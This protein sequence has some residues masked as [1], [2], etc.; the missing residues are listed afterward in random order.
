MRLLHKFML[1]QVCLLA[2][3][4]QQVFAI[5]TPVTLTG[6][7]ADVVAD[8][9]GNAAGSTTADYDGVNYVWMSNS[10]NPGGTYMP[11]GG[12]FTS[13]V[14]STPGL[15]YQ[16]A[17]YTANNSLRMPG[18]STGTL[19]F[20]T[21]QSAQTVFV[22]GSTGS[23]VGTATITITFT[24][25]TTQVFPATVFPDWYNGANYALI[26]VGRTN[27]V[28]NT[29]SNDV[30][31]PRLYQAPLTILPSNYS[32]LIQSVSFSNSGGV[33][34]IMGISID[35][36]P[37][38]CTGTPI[39]GTAAAT[40]TNPCPGVNVNVTLSG[41]TVATGIAYQ[42]LQGTNCTGPW[43][44]ISGLT[45][46]SA[47]TPTLSITTIPGSTIGYRCRLTCTFSGLS[48]TS[49]SACVATFPFT[50][51]SPCFGISS[52]TNAGDQDIF[53]VTVGSLNNTTGCTTPLV[54]SQG[55]GTGTNNMY[56][57][58]SSGVPAPSVFKGLMQS[59]SLTIG[60]CGASTASAVKIYIDFNQN[61]S[62]T[63]IGE[64]VYSNT[65]VSPVVPSAIING[66]FLVP[67]LAPTGCTRMRVVMMS[68]WIG[69]IT[70]TG[71]YAYGETEDYSIN[72]I[73]PSLHDPAIS[74]I[75]VPPGNC[76][77][78][79]ETVNATLCN[80]GSAPINTAATPV[81]VTLT[82]NGPSGVVNYTQTISLGVLPPYGGSCLPVTFTNVDLYAGGAYSINTSLTISGL[83]NGNLTNDSLAIPI[84]RL[85]YRPTG[86]PDYH[87]CQGSLIPFGQGL[88]VSGCATPV[89]DSIV[90]NFT[91]TPG[92]PPICTSTLANPT[93]SCEF[94]S[95]T[96]PA[97]PA[98][99]SFTGN[100]VMRVTNLAS[101]SLGCVLCTWPN[102]KRFSLFQGSAPPT[103]ANVFFPGVSGNP[104]TTGANAQ[105]YTYTNTITPTILGTIYSTLGAGGVL[106][107]G[108]WNTFNTTANNHV[109]NYNGNPTEA[110]L[111]IY[112]TYVPASFEWYA[113]PVGGPILY[114]YSPFDP[115]GVTGSGLSNTNTPGTTPFYAACAG[116]SSCRV[117]VNLVI[118]PTPPAIQDTL[119]LCEYL[120]GSN[121]A[122]FNLTTLDGPVSAFTPGT[123]VE[124]F[125]D[126]G[127]FL[128]ILNPT[129]DTNSTNIIYSKV[130]YAATGCFSS[131]TILLDV[132][133][134]PEFI[135]SPLYG[136][137]C[138]PNSV[139][140]STMINPFTTT[141]GADTLYYSDALCTIPHPNPQAIFAA[142]T[143]YLVL[144][145]NS[146]PVCS[147]TAVA[148]IDIQAASNF[149]A[150][151]DTTSNYST[152]T[153]I[154]CG[155]ITLGDGNT[156]TLFTTSDCRIVATLQDLPNGVSLGTTS[157]CQDIDCG[158]PVHNGQPYINRSYQI[159][160]S[161]QD[162][163]EVC[164][165]Y[166]Q[167][168]FDQYNATVFGLGWPQLLPQSNLC[169][170]KVTNGDL[171]TPG[172][173]A[174][175][176]PQSAITATYDTASTV[177]K[178][179][180]TVGSFSY[181]YCHTCNPFNAPLPVQLLSFTGTKN[182]SFS[183][184]NW[185]TAS[186]SNNAYF[187]VERSENGSSFNPISSFIPT[188]ANG[189][190]SLE[191][192]NYQFIDKQ[193]L[194]GKNYYRLKQVDNDGRHEYS[195]IVQVLHGNDN[196]VR[197][198]PNP[199]SDELHIDMYA[200]KETRA[201]VKMIDATGKV[202]RM[203]EFTLHAGNN[204]NSIDLQGLSDGM[205]L[206]DISDT[207]Q[208]HYRQSV[209][210]R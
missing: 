124:Y 84:S 49:T 174:E 197:I 144:A 100:A 28:T 74:S 48:D 179:C 202:V 61:S 27:T 205:Y 13:A 21:P 140:V 145:T 129:S 178:V 130:S 176:I 78:A 59:F 82:V 65:A 4:T 118:D 51:T 123:V 37:I 90:L 114:T 187:V 209:L 134:K 23:G 55:T 31:N 168:D 115:I 26:G 29:I 101:A 166:L 164:L 111:T 186:E 181:F 91:L 24:D 105:G 143:V 191:K 199:V 72:I 9:P 142:D 32:K 92:Q 2:M 189:G 109:I 147:D 159:T 117:P 106:K 183:D 150:N 87:V 69:A 40:L 83:T 113:N 204:T 139:D 180:F 169:I 210:K 160:P 161:I 119:T 138:A 198:Y 175:N 203:V 85:N 207:K 39:G 5:Y 126:Q 64:E 149:I 14:T 206:V 97:L 153:P 120:T 35:T 185:V 89:N 88:A 56:S 8:I 102:E 137:A 25:L 57:D 52:A 163:A 36:P 200:D 132:V 103:A 177:W 44:P 1:V 68:N 45:N 165:Y 128:P 18:T 16:L 135:S 46:P 41:A 70:P 10:Y 76:F 66:S 73:Q 22:L 43:M 201:F 171:N 54:G 192:L 86:G 3:F 63:D 167:D 121:S 58:F 80:Y 12:L 96:L 20:V 112:Y 98:G 155:N 53:N 94:A 42:W 190:N 131:D 38:P 157:I 60:S 194:S 122:V 173:I 172:H 81:T 67:A 77:S 151:Q 195:S 133:S 148:I 136:N 170:T 188:K 104:A 116:S 99:S 62:F 75:T 19:N 17:S 7:N 47:L 93:N 30:N 152:C 193:P 158:V 95:V 71:T 146:I 110:T 107:M 208:M 6:F 33:L 184:L 196:Q 127:L 79:T 154:G 34:N 15:T 50:C 182:G 162:S 156:E 125:G 11:I 108:S 141:A